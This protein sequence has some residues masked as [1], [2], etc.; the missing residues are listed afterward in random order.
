M[1]QMFNRQEAQA[2]KRP[3]MLMAV[4]FAFYAVIGCSMVLAAG[5]EEPD[6][7]TIGI[8]IDA[9]KGNDESMQS[10]AISLIRE[11]PGAAVTKILARELSNLSVRGQ[12]QLLSALA[13]RG[14]RT[15][16]PAVI[17]ATTSKD[18]SVQIAALK[19]LGQL[20]DSSSVDLL[21]ERAA[22][23]R[24]EEQKAVRNSLYRLR[25]PNV[26]GVILQRIPKVAAKVKVELI[27]SVGERNITAGVEVLLKTARDEDL[28]VRRESLKVLKSVAGPKYLP[29]LVDLLVGVQSSS[30]RREAEKTV[31]VVAHKISDKNKQA[32][33]VLAKLPSVKEEGS[34]CSLL[35]VLGKIGDDS[36]LAV[37]RAGL[38]D[39]NAA[40]KDACIRA[41][42]EWPTAV[43]AGDLLKV[44]QE[45][46]N[47]LHHVLALRGYVRLIGLESNRPAEDT[48][49]MYKQAM[50]LASDTSEKKMVLS[51]LSNVKS[52]AALEMAV[53]FLQDKSLQQEAEVAVVKI[54]ESTVESHAAESKAALQKVID[55]SK[56]DFL[57]KKA[58]ELKSKIKEE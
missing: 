47:K 18:Q 38:K 19:A 22:A 3:E 27:K 58:Q 4:L 55:V 36:A 13:D 25:D 34:R 12:V 54:A 46:D 14:D 53:S 39:K 48:I 5:S 29:A 37:L 16:L 8:V 6:N 45:T 2:A 56:N 49:G 24:G 9:L 32:E 1:T 17:G 52:P 21:A 41:L 7:E 51:G 40:V 44:V 42:A 26:D 20:G 57:R 50:S 23:A 28:K 10:M 33:A 11:M 15:A 31:T 43:A 30:D 35:R